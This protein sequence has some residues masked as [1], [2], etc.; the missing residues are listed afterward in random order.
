M[1]NAPSERVRKTLIRA[2]TDVIARNQY[3]VCT[4]GQL[5]HDAEQ[6]VDHVETCEIVSRQQSKTA[7]AADFGKD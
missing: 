4:C 6:Y 5:F 7:T 2:A 1:P 3:A